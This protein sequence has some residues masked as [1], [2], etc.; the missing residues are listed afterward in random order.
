MPEIPVHTTSVPPFSAALQALRNRI[1]QRKVA[2]V[3]YELGYVGLSLEPGLNEHGKVIKASQIMTLDLACKKKTENI[4]KSPTVGI[5]ALL[6]ERSAMAPSVTPIPIFPQKC[7]YRI[8]LLSLKLTPETISSCDCFVLATDHDSV[9]YESQ[10]NHALLKY[11]WNARRKQRCHRSL[12]EPSS[13]ACKL[14][15]LHATWKNQ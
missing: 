10:R 12:K 13:T 2:V 1:Q 8:D 4:C 5:M 11:P 14:L 6:Y 7:D 3:T 15:A 9:N